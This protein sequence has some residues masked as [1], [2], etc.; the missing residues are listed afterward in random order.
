LEIA[1][2]SKNNV[3]L[4]IG[5]EDYTADIGVVRTKEGIE[6]LVARSR[7]VNA[8]KAAGLQPIDSVFSEIA[9]PDALTDV[10]RQSKGLGFVGMGCIHPKQVPIIHEQYCPLPAEIE[11]A[12]KIIRAF[13]DA[14]KQG[15]G[16]VALGSKMIDAPVVKQAFNVINYAVSAGK[17]SS[18]WRTLENQ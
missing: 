18:E 7:L 17:L 12:K 5:L 15:L 1:L 2:A 6:S 14:K 10:V 3:A 13:E 16:V 8:A 9:D 4:A 11:K